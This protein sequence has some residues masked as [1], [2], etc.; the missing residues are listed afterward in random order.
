MAAPDGN[1]MSDG[2]GA[3]LA[4]VA[5]AIDVLIEKG[6]L[7]EEEIAGK[8]AEAGGMLQ[9]PRLEN[10]DGPQAMGPAAGQAVYLRGGG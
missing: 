10:P 9:A 2:M 1:G 5:A 7:T 3:A 6:V 8:Q 4:R